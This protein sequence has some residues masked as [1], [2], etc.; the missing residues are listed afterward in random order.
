M[1]V[2]VTGSNGFIGRA[3]CKRMIVEGYQVR[4]AVRNATQMT[5]LPSGVE[6]FQVGNICSET[7]WSKALNGINGI[8]HLASRVH[9]MRENTA[10]PVVAIREV[11][12]NG[13]KYLAQQAVEA[14]VKR[15]VYLSTVKVNGEGKATSY[16]EKDKPEP[17]DPYAVSKCES[18]KL[19]HAV[20]YETGLEV[21]IIRSPLVYGPRV[22]ANF[23]RLLEL[24]ES[25]IPLPLKSLNNRRSLIYLGNLV[26]A[27]ITCMKHPNAAGQT[28]FVSDNEDVSTP[29]LMRRMGSALKRPARLFHCP[30]GVLKVAG[31]L[32]GKATEMERLIG[33]L[34]VDISKIIHELDWAPPFSMT[35]G[36]R[37]TGEWYRKKDLQ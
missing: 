3:L 27:I 12:V 13:T 9:V 4:G 25:G 29:T 35:R 18:E 8:I 7:N 32:A 31:R 37:E 22:K 6:A 17:M 23:L 34:T 19:L 30:S 1:N 15:F 36:L 26:D 2:L 10:D 33:S 24:A 5:A 16:T 14:S 21:V 11:N 20:A 28:Y